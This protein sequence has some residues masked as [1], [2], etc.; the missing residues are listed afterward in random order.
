MF[1][2]VRVMYGNLKK[3]FSVLILTGIV[4]VFSSPSFA[5][6]ISPSSAKW[7]NTDGKAESLIFEIAGIDD[8]TALEFVK[9][10]LRVIFSKDEFTV[11]GGKLTVLNTA[12]V[13][14]PNGTYTMKATTANAY[15]EIVTVSKPV[16]EDMTFLLPDFTGADSLTFK[17]ATGMI[18]FDPSE[19]SFDNTTKMLTIKKEAFA[20]EIVAD[21]VYEMKVTENI[22]EET[23][24]VA[25]KGNPEKQTEEEKK[26]EEEKTSGGSGGGGCNAGFGALALL[27]V[28]GLFYRKKK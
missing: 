6:A 27:G 17:P 13:K 22:G 26:Q 7:D 1:L 24:E 3:I 15:K 12:L 9:D 18:N 2:E 11:D 23:A 25:I 8:V 19:F 16:S 28:L 14:T 20:G 5:G 4:L 21:G 10:S